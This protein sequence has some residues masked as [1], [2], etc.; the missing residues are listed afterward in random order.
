V[1]LV[2]GSDISLAVISAPQGFVVGSDESADIAGVHQ[3][4]RPLRHVPSFAIPA[5]GMIGNSGS[6]LT[7]P[8]FSEAGS[9]VAY[10]CFYVGSSCQASYFLVVKPPSMSLRLKGHPF[11]V[12]LLANQHDPGRGV[13][14]A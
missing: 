12:R 1:E 13:K 7:I 8:L 10:I 5:L 6:L 4:D 11:A 3:S 14:V 9:R 2:Q